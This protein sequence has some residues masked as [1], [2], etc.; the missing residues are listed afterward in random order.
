MYLSL[1]LISNK[2][3]EEKNLLLIS[4]VYVYVISVNVTAANTLIKHNIIKA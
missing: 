4:N 3:I 2:V 1:R